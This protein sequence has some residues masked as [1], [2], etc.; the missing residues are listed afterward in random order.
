MH[1]MRVNFGNS[2]IER[3]GSLT[4]KKEEKWPFSPVIHRWN[5]DKNNRFSKK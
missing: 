1:I 5:S 4:R 2:H 3:I